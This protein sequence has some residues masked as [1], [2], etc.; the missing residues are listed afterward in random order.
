MD[1]AHIAQTRYTTKAFSRPKR[2][3]K[4]DVEAVPHP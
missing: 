1:I 3:G 4:K 2:P